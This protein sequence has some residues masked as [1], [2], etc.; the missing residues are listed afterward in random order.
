[1]NMI[2]EIDS[3]LN[4]MISNGVF[5]MSKDE[6]D[7]CSFVARRI[8][9][10]GRIFAGRD[11]LTLDDTIQTTIDLFSV[12]DDAQIIDKVVS[13]LEK[14]NIKTKPVNNSSHGI[15]VFSTSIETVKDSRDLFSFRHFTLPDQFGSLSPLYLGH[16]VHHALKDIN[17]NE[18]QYKLRYADVIPLFF[19]L[20]S[21]DKYKDIDR[22]LI[23]N[24]RIEM[25][26]QC[27]FMLQDHYANSTRTIFN[28]FN[29]SKVCQ[30]LG[31]F[32]YAVALYIMYQNN[33]HKILDMV[34]KVLLHEKSTY[35][36]LSDNNIGRNFD[37]DVSEFMKVLQKK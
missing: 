20:I 33:P 30:Y 27:K 34:K 10:G 19:E 5:S 16:E 9:E 18:Y 37:K 21:A 11:V 29:N 31:S 25:L 14:D 8:P 22:T 1:M 4:R 23:L 32:Y 17:P 7:V 26:F 3:I 35:D 28:E 6:Y 24:N 12:Y 2:S 15:N 36:I 13:L